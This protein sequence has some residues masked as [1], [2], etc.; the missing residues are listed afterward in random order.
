MSPGADGKSLFINLSEKKPDTTVTIQ[1]VP[2][3][4]EEATEM[5]ILASRALSRMLGW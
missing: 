3:S 1:G 2:I 4:L 5:K